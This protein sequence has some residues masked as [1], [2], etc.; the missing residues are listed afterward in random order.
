MAKYCACN[1]VGTHCIVPMFNI[2]I[3][4]LGSGIVDISKGFENTDCNN[5]IR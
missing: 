4:P 3:D 5:E 1:D 2:E